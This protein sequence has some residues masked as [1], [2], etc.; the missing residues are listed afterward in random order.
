V[1]TDR[2][3]TGPDGAF[4]FAG[5]PEGSLLVWARTE[6]GF[7]SAPGGPDVALTLVPL[8]SVSGKVAGKPSLLGGARAI[9][10]GGF[11]RSVEARVDE[12]SGRFDVARVP[13][14]EA[15]LSVYRNNFEV[16]RVPVQVVPGE[17]TKVK[18]VRVTEEFLDDGDPLVDVTR[19]RLVGSEGR[20]VAGVQLV[21]SSRWMDGGMDSD[22]EGIVR[23]AGGGVA[24]GGPPYRLRTGALGGDE[25]PYHGVLKGERGGVAVVEIHPLVAVSGTVSVGGK[26]APLYRLHAVTGGKA[27]RVRTATVEKGRYAVRLPEGTSRVVVVTPDGVLHEGSLDVAG[28]DAATHDLALP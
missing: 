25:T 16:A 11:G 10:W 20:P 3:K 24:I 19:V 14:G 18:A 13:P 21:W 28:S 6:D 5:V 12:D 22:A 15:W 2:A 23:L 27:P 7:A 17:A 26:P 1:R 8:G 9:V 4:R